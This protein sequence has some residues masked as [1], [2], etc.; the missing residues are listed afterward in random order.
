MFANGKVLLQLFNKS[1]LRNGTKTFIE[2]KFFCIYSS[3]AQPGRMRLSVW[4]NAAAQPGRMRLSVWNNAAVKHTRNSKHTAW[5]PYKHTWKQ[6]KGTFKYH[7]SVFWAILDP[8]PY[9]GILT[10]LANPLPHKMFSIY[11]PHT[12]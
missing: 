11:S 8:S 7:M 9:D 4:N 3:G 12:P 10:F 2:P 5:R 1:K 6:N